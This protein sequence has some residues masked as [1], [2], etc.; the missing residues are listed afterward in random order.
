[1][2]VERGGR[3]RGGREREGEKKSLNRDP[4]KTLAAAT[5]E[6]YLYR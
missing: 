2:M 4:H 3:E 5:R 1:M 6:R